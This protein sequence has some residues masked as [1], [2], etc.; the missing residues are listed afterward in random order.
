MRKTLSLVFVSVSVV[1]GIVSSCNQAKGGKLAQETVS[2]QDLLFQRFEYLKQY[3]VTADA[4]PR[5]YESDVKKV[6]VM[7]SKSWTSGFYRVASGIFLN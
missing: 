7:P 1:L 2:N 4:F 5:S 6:R 3:P